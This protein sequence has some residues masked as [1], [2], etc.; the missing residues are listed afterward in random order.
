MFFNIKNNI[1]VKFTEPC[2]IPYSSN[3]YYSKVEPTF[4]NVS[5]STEFMD[6]EVVTVTC[7]PGF[8]LKGPTRMECRKG[9]WD[10]GSAISEC[11]PGD[12]IILKLNKF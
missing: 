7:F 12:I 10:V 9:E 1:N 5:E 11:T 4:Q 6:T 8:N 2:L 3:G